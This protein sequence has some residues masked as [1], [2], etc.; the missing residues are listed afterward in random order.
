MKKNLYNYKL[1]WLILFCIKLTISTHANQKV[2]ISDNVP[3]Q[4]MINEKGIPEGLI[5]ELAK[6]IFG[7]VSFEGFPL[8]RA[9]E[10]TAK[11]KNSILFMSRTPQREDKYIW[12]DTIYM[13]P[14]Y[15]YTKKGK[16]PKTEDYLSLFKSISVI[17][18]SSLIQVLQEKKYSEEFTASLN[19]EQNLK[20]ILFDRADGW[21]EGQIIAEYIIK[22]EKYNIK[23]FDMYG[24]IIKNTTWIATSKTSEQNFVIKKIEEIKLFKKEKKYNSIL[25]K[26]SAKKPEN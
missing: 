12:L 9:L 16:F 19:N 22:N 14:V 11:E 21:I 8:A 20:K 26:Y 25:N 17:N 1:M 18:G 23:K 3:P 5:V 15:I 24:P 6:G 10:I 7:N 4:S 13:T 2:N